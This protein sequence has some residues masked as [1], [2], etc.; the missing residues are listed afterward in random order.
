VTKA[1]A[2]EV[3]VLDFDDQFGREGLPFG[4]AVGGPPARAAGRVAGKAGWLDYFSSFLVSAGFS[5]ALIPD[6][7][8]T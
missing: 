3:I 5:P 2:G 4:G 8:P 7:K 6:V 1:A